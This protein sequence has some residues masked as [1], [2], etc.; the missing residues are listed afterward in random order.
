MA[1]GRDTPSGAAPL[2][3]ASP[4]H[5]PRTSCLLHNF[6]LLHEACLTHSATIV[7]FVSRVFGTTTFTLAQRWLFSNF[8]IDVADVQDPRK[9]YCPLRGAKIDQSGCGQDRNSQLC[10]G[11]RRVDYSATA[12]LELTWR[13]DGSPVVEQPV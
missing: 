10:A 1:C 9:V 6:L 11:K 4:A 5:E 13:K 2:R 3:R 7:Y 12:A 8:A